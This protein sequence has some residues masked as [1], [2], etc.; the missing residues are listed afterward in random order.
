MWTVI[1]INQDE[2]KSFVYFFF[3]KENFID[4]KNLEKKIIK[5]PEI[6]KSLIQTFFFLFSLSQYLYTDKHVSIYYYKKNEIICVFS[7][8]LIFS[9]KS[10]SVFSLIVSFLVIILQHIYF[11][12]TFFVCLSLVFLYVIVSYIMFGFFPVCVFCRFCV[13]K[14]RDKQENNFKIFFDVW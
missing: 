9:L 6:K 12:K 7:V 13:L 3:L 11:I 5:T 4:L 8:F 1:R 14:K 2:E 10:T